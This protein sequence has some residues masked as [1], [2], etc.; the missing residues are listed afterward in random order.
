MLF[1]S[2]WPLDFLGLGLELLLDNNQTFSLF[3][4]GFCSSWYRQLERPEENIDIF[5]HIK[6]LHEQRD[7]GNTDQADVPLDED[8]DNGPLEESILTNPIIHALNLV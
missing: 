6:T 5:G 2:L 8:D 7:N 1:R 3:S 4:D